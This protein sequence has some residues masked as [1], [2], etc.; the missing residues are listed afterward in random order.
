MSVIGNDFVVMRIWP[1]FVLLVLGLGCRTQE[2]VTDDLEPVTVTRD[3]SQEPE[4]PVERVT[5]REGDTDGVVFIA[6]YHRITEE[7]GSFARSRDNFRKDLER[8]YEM[9]F[10]PVTL[11][12]YIDEEMDLPPGASPVVMT[13]DDS[14]FSQFDYLEDGTIDPDSGVGIWLEFAKDHPDFPVRGSFFVVKNGPFTRDGQRKVRQLLEW[15]CEVDSH[16][17]NHNSLYNMTDDQVKAELSAAQEYINEI[18]ST[19]RFLCLPMG[20]RP[21]N[22]ELL[23]SFEW[24]GKRYTHEA[25]L[26]VGAGPAPS[27]SDPDR[28]VYRLPRIQAY[29]GEYGLTYWLDQVEEGKVR[30]YVQP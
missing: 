27:P 5:D 11:G 16:T 2:P 7:E 30:P 29:D 3:H 4:E 23:K 24:N 17:I 14:H 19:P 8:L 26:M 25:A 18:G 15:G 20:I 1:L 13:W 22:R 10:R 6:M 12:E 9:G 28:D 21:K